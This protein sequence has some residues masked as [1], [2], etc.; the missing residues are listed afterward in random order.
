MERQ[1]VIWDFNGTILD[2]VAL[3]IA[4]ANELLLRHGLAPIRDVDHYHSVFGFPII[5]YYRRLGF[6]FSKI[7]YTV[8]ANE[9]VEIYNRLSPMATLRGGVIEVIT[10][11]KERGCHQ[12]ILSMTEETMLRRQL[13]ELGIFSLFDEIYGRSDIYASSKLL[14]AEKW[15]CDH[16]DVRP[17][18][19]GDTTHDAESADVIGATC[20]MLLG[21]HESEAVLKRT[22][23]PLLHE[24]SELF[25]YLR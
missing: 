18:Y 16:P 12:S 15:R 5:D 7:D 14:L 23:F 21:G 25:H 10:E 24:P 20:L 22:G 9:W 17:L 6:D 11:L 1:Y 2:D 3:G 13:S 8:L 19:V 4:S